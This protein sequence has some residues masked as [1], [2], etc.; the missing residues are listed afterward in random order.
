MLDINILCVGIIRNGA[1]CLHRSVT[2]IDKAFSFTTKKQ[3][4]IIESDSDDN[5]VDLLDSLKNEIPNF[6][7]SSMGSLK[8]RMPHRTERIAFCRNQY[9]Q[10]VFENPRFAEV[11]YVVMADLDGV[12]DGLNWQAALSCWTRTDW[13]ACFANQ[14]G[15][16]YDVWALRHPIWSPNDCWQQAAFLSHFGMNDDYA[17][18][19]SV[20]SRMMEIPSTSQWIPVTSAFGG[21]GIYKKNILK[22][23]QFRGLGSSGAPECEWVSFNEHL[24]H[25]GYKLFINPQMINGGFNEHSAIYKTALQ[26]MRAIRAK[27]LEVSE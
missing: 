2:T 14:S 3:W 22:D 10:H 11:E 26:Q 19:V 17:R 1:S 4:L 20:A 5:T 24:C 23:L 25:K 6:F 7:F 13:D 9:L 12:N 15:A 16:Y 18:L 27:E 8:E 21:L